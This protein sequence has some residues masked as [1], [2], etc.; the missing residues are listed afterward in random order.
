MPQYQKKTTMGKGNELLNK[1]SG[2]L[3][4]SP[5]GGIVDPS[6]GAVS[7]VNLAHHMESFGNLRTMATRNANGLT[8]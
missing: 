3:H 1:N 6:S 8:T 5:S 2:L 7:Q 4:Q